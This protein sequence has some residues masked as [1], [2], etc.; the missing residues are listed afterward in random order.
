[1]EEDQANLAVGVGANPLGL[2]M[3]DNSDDE[4]DDSDDSGESG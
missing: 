4:D 1:M 2:Q 3:V